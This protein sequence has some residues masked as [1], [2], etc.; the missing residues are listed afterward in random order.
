MRG[1]H[2]ILYYAGTRNHC[3]EVDGVFYTDQSDLLEVLDDR[4]R[5]IIL[6]RFGPGFNPGLL[7]SSCPFGAE[8][9]QPYRLGH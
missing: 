6:Q 1:Y 3:C 4:E 5:K 7:V 8:H 9:C 2:C